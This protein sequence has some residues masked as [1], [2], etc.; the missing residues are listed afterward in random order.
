M[1]LLDEEAILRPTFE[2]ACGGIVSSCG[3]AARPF[4]RLPELALTKRSEATLDAHGT[5]NQLPPLKS[6]CSP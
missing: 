3:P 5:S 1:P 4:Q 2:P 6:Y